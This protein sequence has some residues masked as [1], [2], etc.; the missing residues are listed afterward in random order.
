[1]SPVF[2]NA[3]RPR[4]A[5]LAHLSSTDT[6]RRTWY[7]LHWLLVLI[8]GPGSTLPL[9]SIFQA[10][11][12]APGAPWLGHVSRSFRQWGSVVITDQ[13]PADMLRACPVVGR[14][15]QFSYSLRRRLCRALYR[16]PIGVGLSSAIP[17]P[18]PAPS[19]LP[20][21]LLS[22]RPCPDE[23]EFF[24]SPLLPVTLLPFFLTTW[25]KK[26]LAP[27]TPM[28]PVPRARRTINRG[29]FTRTHTHTHTRTNSRL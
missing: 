4:L 6:A 15:S 3:W 9:G 16:T 5:F 17:S 20:H 29:G 25:E 11:A 28:C 27:F 2:H 7:T 13:V 24:P 26:H 18:I 8:L 23:G 14:K 22:P 21:L 19:G 10:R 12:P 1:M